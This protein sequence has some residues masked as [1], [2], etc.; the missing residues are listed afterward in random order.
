VEGEKEGAVF[1]GEDAEEKQYYC[2]F[3]HFSSDTASSLLLEE[4]VLGVEAGREERMKG[5]Y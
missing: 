5:Q 4:A 1:E 2:F 3:Y